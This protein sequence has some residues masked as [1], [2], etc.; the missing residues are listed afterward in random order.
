MQNQLKLSVVKQKGRYLQPPTSTKSKMFNFTEDTSHGTISDGYKHETFLRSGHIQDGKV[1]KRARDPIREPGNWT[2]VRSPFAPQ[3]MPP[4]ERSSPLNPLTVRLQRNAV[5]PDGT[6]K[7][8]ATYGLVDQGEY[9]MADP[10]TLSYESQKEQNQLTQALIAQLAQNSNDQEALLTDLINE[11]RSS[12]GLSA[13]QLQQLLALQEA[14]AQKGGVDPAEIQAKIESY[15]INSLRKEAKDSVSRV[16]D[17]FGIG[18]ASRVDIG[19]TPVKARLVLPDE[20]TNPDALP[21]LSDIE[22]SAPLDVA[23]VENIKS[24]LSI[25][26]VA[27]LTDNP[28]TLGQTDIEETLKNIRDTK[29]AVGLNGVS[30]NREKAKLYTILKFM[31]RNSRAPNLDEFRK[32]RKELDKI[33][34]F[35]KEI[36]GTLGNMVDS[37]FV[38]PRPMAVGPVGLPPPPPA[39]A[40]LSKMTPAKPKPAKSRK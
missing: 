37:I 26:E 28:I 9:K 12:G 31:E 29:Q 4:A 25:F 27:S 7:N 38:K 36:Y 16:E 8:N 33:S 5:Y 35:P 18:S 21:T 23:N 6:P 22:F 3:A 40:S 30:I 13:D 11:V 39:A 1:A 32:I 15:A 19:K 2:M 34:K 14:T 10:S 17:I 24:Y 20:K